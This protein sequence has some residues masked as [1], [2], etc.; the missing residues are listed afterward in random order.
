MYCP[1]LGKG[2]LRKR[3]NVW[4]KYKHGSA[5]IMFNAP[6]TYHNVSGVSGGTNSFV[7]HRNYM[8]FD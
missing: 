3:L 8:L 4:G 7:E 6:S 2:E 1:L 5:E